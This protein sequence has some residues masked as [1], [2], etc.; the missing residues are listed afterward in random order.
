MDRGA[1]GD[2]PSASCQDR[3]VPDGS[4]GHVDHG[5]SIRGRTHCHRQRARWQFRDKSHHQAFRRLR[6]MPRLAGLGEPSA[7]L[8]DW[9]RGFGRPIHARAGS[10][11]SLYFPKNWSR[12]N[13]TAE[14]SM[15]SP[16]WTR[17]TVPRWATKCSGPSV[18]MGLNRA[19]AAKVEDLDRPSH[20]EAPSGR[21]RLAGRAPP[22]RSRWGCLSRR[23]LRNRTPQRRANASASAWFRAPRRWLVRASCDPAG[24]PNCDE[25]IPRRSRAASSDRSSS[26]APG[27]RQS[28][29]LIGVVSTGNWPISRPVGMIGARAAA[30]QYPGAATRV[31]VAARNGIAASVARPRAADADS[32]SRSSSGLGAR[33][34]SQARRARSGSRAGSI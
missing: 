11:R 21:P 28:A 34:K 16:T 29:R 7:A 17:N 6:A 4:C 30:Q 13:S 24:S 2:S 22:A 26:Y 18:A 9:D 33:W 31:A 1:N 32:R 15:H 10:R 3:S 8:R 23:R 5:I 27:V 19:E 20:S 12:G 25:D 14:G